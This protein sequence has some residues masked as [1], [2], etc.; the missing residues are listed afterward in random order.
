MS[1]E[2]AQPFLFSYETLTAELSDQIFILNCEDFW[3]EA[4]CSQW[5]HL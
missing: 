1:G 3:G 2:K 5:L 4:F